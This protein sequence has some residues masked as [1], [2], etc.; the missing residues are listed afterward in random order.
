MRTILPSPA[1]MLAIGSRK[2]A[3]D[4]RKADG[5]LVDDAVAEHVVQLVDGPEHGS[6]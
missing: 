6:A 2:A 4:R 3:A 5:D 1:A